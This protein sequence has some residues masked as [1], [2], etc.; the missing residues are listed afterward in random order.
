MT[1]SSIMV[2]LALFGCGNDRAVDM[3]QVDMAAPTGDMAVP[4]L[5]ST[6]SVARGE[7]L[8]KHLLLCGTCHT[9]PDASG[10]PSTNAT[11]F[12]AGGRVFTLTSAGDGGTVTVYAPNLTPDN[13]TGLGSW[14]QSQIVDAMKVGVDAQGLPLWPTMPYQRFANLRDDDAT[15]IAM[16]L[17]TLPPQ[18]HAVPDDSA[19]PM[20][21]SPVFDYT[22]LPHTTLIHGDPNYAAAE[23][24]RY[25]A[26]LGCLF[27]HT[28]DGP[29]PTGIDVGKAY[30]GGR[31]F[32]GGVKSSNL[33]PEATGLNLWN[34]S[35][36]I[37]T[38]KAD[39]EMGTG[40]MLLP[41]MPGGTGV[42]RVGGLFDADLQDLA[43]YIHTLPP[44]A[45]GP[46]GP[47]DM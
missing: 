20:L 43:Q 42:D 12:L 2:A 18:N 13:A 8:V 30:A 7:E 37:A 10:A 28:V 35:D 39:K 11:D 17:Q 3:G 46:F 29:P 5:A 9:T 16:Y 6:A 4:D 27:C 26:S 1:R 21:A 15:S 44:V 32:G 41:P 14:T 25:V 24:G 31:A 23:R 40:R 36:I 38:L 19:H 47:P 22:T 45:N 33:T 34:T